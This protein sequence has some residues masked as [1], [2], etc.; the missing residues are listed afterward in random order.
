MQYEKILRVALVPTIVFFLL[1]LVSLALTTHYWILGD[2][3]VPR[4]VRIGTDYTIVY[5]KDNETDATVA[6]ACLNLSAAVMALIAWSTLRKPGMDTQFAA[7]KRRFWVLSVVVMTITGATA[8]LASLILHFSAKGND[9]FGCDSETL[10]M[11][12]KKN[13]NKFCTREMASCNFLPKYL[14]GNDRDNAAIACNEAVVVKWLQ[15]IIVFNALIVLALFS[16]QAR[17]RRT[18]R[19]FRA[20]DSLP[21]DY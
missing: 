3:I 13:T 17:M 18:T 9:P 1:S 19:E 5:F 16:V 2:W 15:L 10:M 7:G 4:G 14:K 6:S 12:G 21:K 11:S 20:I 8:A